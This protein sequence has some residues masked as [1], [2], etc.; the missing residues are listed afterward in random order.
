MIEKRSNLINHL[1]V[2]ILDVKDFDQK[3]RLSLKRIKVVNVYDQF[4]NREYI[5]LGAYIRR[6]R[7]IKDIN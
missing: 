6:R 7:T 2:I 3:I 5:Y 4:I 1:Y